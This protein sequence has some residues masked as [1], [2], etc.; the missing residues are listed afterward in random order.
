M[1]KIIDFAF[2]ASGAQEK[3]SWIVTF[4]RLFDFREK[5]ASSYNNIDQ[6]KSQGF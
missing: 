2:S 6:V 1:T 4:E 3:W 5:G